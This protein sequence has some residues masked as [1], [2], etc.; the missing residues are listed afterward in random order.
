MKPNQRRIVWLLYLI[1]I[2]EFFFFLFVI[3]M[4]NVVQLERAL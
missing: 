1:T 3:L 4:L 2:V